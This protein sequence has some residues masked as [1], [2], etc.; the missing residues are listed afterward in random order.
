[1]E[2]QATMFALKNLFNEK[3]EY[4]NTHD[5]SFEKKGD[6]HV[7]VVSERVGGL[8]EGLMKS[9]EDKA[10]VTKEVLKRLENYIKQVEGS[11]SRD[12]NNVNAV[13]QHVRVIIGKLTANAPNHPSMQQ[14]KELHSRLDKL[15]KEH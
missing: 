8:G 3:P 6:A 4:W 2:P 13:D 5:L 9:P 7:L 12:K 1:M 10:K 15:R 14:Y 11:G